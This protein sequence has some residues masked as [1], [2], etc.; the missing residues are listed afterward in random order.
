MV[1]PEWTASVCS[2][3]QRP[4]R[5]TSDREGAG[6]ILRILVCR[7][8][9]TRR[10]MCVVI[11]SIK[12]A[13]TPQQRQQVFTI[14]G[15]LIVDTQC[16]FNFFFKMVSGFVGCL[17]V[18]LVQNKEF[19]RN[20]LAWNWYDQ[21]GNQV[22]NAE[23]FKSDFVNSFITYFL[24]FFSMHLFASLFWKVLQKWAVYCLVFWRKLNDIDASKAGK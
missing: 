10:G 4:P 20:L 11:P 22:A 19:Q 15:N 18:K 8:I 9:I 23:C 17:K 7:Y 1:L 24:Y 6:A 21:A 2:N 12:P 13:E 14:W 3:P 16:F 5:P